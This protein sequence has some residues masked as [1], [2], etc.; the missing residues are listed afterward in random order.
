M[1]ENVTKEAHKLIASH[2]K[3]RREEMK[4]T[5][6]QLA[7][8]MGIK[9]AAISRMESG[10]YAPSLDMFFEWCHHL[11][12]YF[13]VEGKDSPSGNTPTIG[14]TVLYRPTENEREQMDGNKQ[15]ILPAVIVSVSGP[16]TVNLKVITD[17][18]NDL[19]VTSRLKGQESG[20]WDWPVIQK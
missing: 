3:G 1:S 14:R 6:E 7:D 13:F 10:L 11:N 4:M 5:Q 2:L 16:E 8:K 18:K 19:W 9:K 12:L 15:E 20:Q 17:A